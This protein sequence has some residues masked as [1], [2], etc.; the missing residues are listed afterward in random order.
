MD[1]ARSLVGNV[2]PVMAASDYGNQ[3][4]MFSWRR[5]PRTSAAVDSSLMSAVRLYHQ[6][7]ERVVSYSSAAATW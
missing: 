1:T 3:V 5:L 2:L 7:P 6:S 4:A